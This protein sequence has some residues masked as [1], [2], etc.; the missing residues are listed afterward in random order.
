MGPISQTWYEENVPY[1]TSSRF[2]SI[3]N[4]EIEVKDFTESW[5]GGRIDISGVPNEP[6]GLEYGLSTMRSENW[7][8]FSEWLKGVQSEE[9]L[10]LNQLLKLYNKPIHWFN[11]EL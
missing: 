6:Y 11:K 9:L 3:L 4:K 1:V 10:T 2:N 5:S 7:N 8:E